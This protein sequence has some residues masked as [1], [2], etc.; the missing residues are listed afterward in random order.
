MSLDCL[1]S[2]SLSR[3]FIH[4]PLC[5]LSRTPSPPRP[6]SLDL[7]PTPRA[8]LNKIAGKISDRHSRKGNVCFCKSCGLVPGER[9]LLRKELSVMCGSSMRKRAFDSYSETGLG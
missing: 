3:R 2:G 1:E 9:G 5:G 7:T 4:D 6:S 8:S